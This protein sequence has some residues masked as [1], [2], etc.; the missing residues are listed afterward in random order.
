MPDVYMRLVQYKRVANAATR[1]ELEELEVEMIN[2]F[3][4]LAEPTKTLFGVTW[5]KLLA[6]GLGVEKLVA[7]A[8]GGS[9]RFGKDSAVD[10]E[11][12]IRL[13]SEKRAH[14]SLDGPYRLRFRWDPPVPEDERIDR[15]ERLLIELGAAEPE[16]PG[17]PEDGRGHQRM[18]E[19]PKVQAL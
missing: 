8:H 10:A 7:G 6:A 3:G 15:L 9:I 19:S 16:A 14:Y 5:I 17:A 1:N 11:A 18:P 12:L 13:I 2:R 4:L